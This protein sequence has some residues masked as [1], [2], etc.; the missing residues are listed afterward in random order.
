MTKGLRLYLQGD[1]PPPPA[2]AGRRLLIT[3]PLD[4]AVAMSADLESRGFAALIE[5]MLSIQVLPQPVLEFQ[6]VHGLIFT[7][8]NAVRALHQVVLERDLKRE[9]EDHQGQSYY[10]WDRLKRLPAYTVGDSTASCAREFGFRKVESAAGKAKDL[11]LM[12]AEKMRKGQIPDHSILLHVSGKNRAGDLETPLIRAGLGLRRAIVYKAE[13]AKA[14]S[15]SVQRALKDRHLHGV[16]FFSPRTAE[17]FVTLM[18]RAG[19][20]SSCRFLEAY[21]LSDA[22]LEACRPLPWYRVHLAA[23]PNRFSLLSLL[24]E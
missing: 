7:S 6:D 10:D 15:L 16:L 8:A 12:L 20:V 11:A 13:A 18:E 5:P 4:E 2:Q 23:E 24:P 19:L 3:R 14:L 9:A 1:L 17:T 22:V 21:C